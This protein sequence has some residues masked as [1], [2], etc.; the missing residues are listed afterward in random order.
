MVSHL[1][2]LQAHHSSDFF[3]QK[4]QSKKWEIYGFLV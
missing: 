1:A 2:F 4:F 3:L